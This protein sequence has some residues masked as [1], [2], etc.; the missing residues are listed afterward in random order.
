[1][2]I[3]PGE[4]II[5]SIMEE[6]VNFELER[7]QNFDNEIKSANI[8][9]PTS[10]KQRLLR[11]G[12]LIFL[13]S[14]SYWSLGIAFTF[15]S[16]LASDL[17]KHNT[18]IY[19][20]YIH[21]TETEKDLVGSFIPVGALFGAYGCGWLASLKGRRSCL[22]LIAVVYTISW[23]G[24]GFAP[25][26]YSILTCR[27]LNGFGV[28]CSMV[29]TIFYATELSDPC[30]RGNMLAMMPVGQM[31]GQLVIAV[32]GYFFRY[33]TA[34]LIC[35]FFT[36][37][38]LIACLIFPESPTILILR[39]DMDT[40]HA[41]LSSLRGKHVNI[42]DE[43]QTCIDKNK[44]AKDGAWKALLQKNIAKKL[45]IIFFLFFFNVFSGTMILV[46][47]ASRIFKSSGSSIEE[48]IA[49]IIVMG[50][51]VVSV[52]LLA[53][54]LIVLAERKHSWGVFWACH[55]HWDPCLD[56]LL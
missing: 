26:T 18:T 28:G 55:Y 7:G 12:M 24:M 39:D 17:D 16:V 13:A 37:L 23:I 32:L 29:T 34:S 14:M 31:S 15:P 52:F 19:G 35:S 10:R 46:S 27:Y 48:E 53:L 56:I 30:V 54:F 50:V 9:S 38:M 1:M 3:F 43:I 22:I 11:Q 4:F 45:A 42:K 25:N 21:L 5:F 49:T 36:L 33:Y 41:V 6:V 47:Y 51:Q 20:N 40:A 8:E 44:S 2:N